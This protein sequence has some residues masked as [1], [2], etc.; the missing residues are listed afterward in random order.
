MGG[1][2]PRSWLSTRSDSHGVQYWQVL[3]RGTLIG[4]GHY[5]SPPVLHYRLKVDRVVSVLPSRIYQ[6]ECGVFDP[7]AGSPPRE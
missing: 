3:M 7:P 5:G 1:S 4:P 6:D 2:H